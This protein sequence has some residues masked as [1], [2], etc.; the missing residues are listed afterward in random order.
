MIEIRESENGHWEKKWL[1]R[2]E[3][4]KFLHKRRTCVRQ[5]GK[6]ETLNA[7]RAVWKIFNMLAESYKHVCGD[8]RANE[9][10]FAD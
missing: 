5:A 2:L 4:F 1:S 9:H 6:R 8:S 10:L 3:E 7:S